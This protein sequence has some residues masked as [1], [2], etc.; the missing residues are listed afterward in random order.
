MIRITK[1]TQQHNSKTSTKDKNNN[2]I[3]KSLTNKSKRTITVSSQNTLTITLTRNTPATKNDPCFS[4]YFINIS[5][6]KN[7]DQAVVANTISFHAS[8]LSF[9]SI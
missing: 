1:T 2:M 4:H 8:T 7:M 9:F 3:I 6:V 5:I